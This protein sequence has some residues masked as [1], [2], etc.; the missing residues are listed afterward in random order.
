MIVKYYDLRA[1]AIMIKS[2]KIEKLHGFYDYFITFNDDINILYGEN[3]CGKTTILKIINIIFNNRIVELFDYNFD[4]IMIEFIANNGAIQNFDFHY[5]ADIIKFNIND[6]EIEVFKKGNINDGGIFSKLKEQYSILFLDVNR[7]NGFHKER[8]S[9]IKRDV[10]EH[11]IFDDS[12][13]ENELNGVKETIRKNIMIVNKRVS[14]ED[15][16]FKLDILKSLIAMD[17][18]YNLNSMSELYENVKMFFDDING[19]Y[20]RIE[21]YKKKFIDI[22]SNLRLNDIFLVNQYEAFFDNYT[23]S[24]KNMLDNLIEH[25]K[26][27]DPNMDPVILTQLMVS[28]FEFNRIKSIIEIA[29]KYD[30]IKNKHKEKINMFLS[31]VN[32]FIGSNEEKQVKIDEGSGSIFFSTNYSKF[33]SINN[34]SAGEKQ[35]LNIF[36]F[37]IFEM[38]NKKKRMF[39]IDEPE[40]SLHLSWQ[41]MFIEAISE[42]SPN[43]QIILATHSPEI[44]GKFRNK[45]VYLE[46]HNSNRE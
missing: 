24:L 45:L 4:H 11:F 28:H 39:L 1:G 38:N 13:D 19:Y 27:N 43:V 17:N 41:K 3:G 40:L 46:K 18:K 44:V 16:N 2:I 37:L 33:I 34:L 7:M 23:E 29:I 9:Y 22:L 20:E 36:T 32:K 12:F 31:S 42:I 5:T 21:R 6:E 26:N 15:E 25:S 30:S 14:R 35:I 8:K 10:L